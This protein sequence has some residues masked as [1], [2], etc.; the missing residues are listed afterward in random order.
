MKLRTNKNGE[1]NINKTKV[2]SA[3]Y[4]PAALIQYFSMNKLKYNIL[5]I[6]LRVICHNV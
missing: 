5:F 4:R 2:Q 1:E 3:H 6:L